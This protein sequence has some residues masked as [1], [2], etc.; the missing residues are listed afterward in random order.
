MA[1]ALKKSPVTRELDFCID[2][3]QV[4]VT[5]DMMDN[6]P[7]LH[8]RLK[9]YKT[10]WYINLENLSQIASWHPRLK[11]SD[12]ELMTTPKEN[13]KKDIESFDWKTKYGK[14]LI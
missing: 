13:L 2:E 12:M 7:I 8:L 1:T 10:G 5:L 3:R 11:S 9:G 4:L 14:D 6:K